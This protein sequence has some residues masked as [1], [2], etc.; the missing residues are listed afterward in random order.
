MENDAQELA[1]GKFDLNSIQDMMNTVLG[2][3][4]QYPKVVIG[5]G[6]AIAI[7]GVALAA[8]QKT[9]EAPKTEAKNAR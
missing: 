3:C 2:Y 5:I 8:M 4:K 9:E 1:E 6:V 7:A